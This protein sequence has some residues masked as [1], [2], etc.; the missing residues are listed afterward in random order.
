LSTLNGH[1]ALKI[2]NGLNELPLS[3]KAQHAIKLKCGLP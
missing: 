3:S 1:Q 2:T